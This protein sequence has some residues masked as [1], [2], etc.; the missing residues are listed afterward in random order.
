MSPEDPD[1][2]MAALLFEMHGDIKVIK[3]QTAAS[4]EV[5]KDHE[6]RLR[7]LEKFRYAIPGVALIG[8]VATA[9]VAFHPIT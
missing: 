9:L 8:A 4:N 1:F 2:A 5:Q 3:A 6:N 7:G